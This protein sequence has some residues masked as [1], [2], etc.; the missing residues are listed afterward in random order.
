MANNLKSPPKFEE[1]T[2]YESWKKD[3]RLWTKLTDLDKKKQGIAVYLSLTGQARNLVSEVPEEDFCKDTGVATVLEK[4]DGLFLADKSL[5]Q[6]A[7][8]NKLYNLRRKD[9][10]PIGDFISE[11]EHVY[12]EFKGQEMT[13]P[14]SVQAFALLSGC[15]H[16]I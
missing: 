16:V 1:G 15:Q 7:A 11:F 12:F 4:L 14:D 2:S 6:F 10:T 5:R 9:N 8:F 13:L 3:V